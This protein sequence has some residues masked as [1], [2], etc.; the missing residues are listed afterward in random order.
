MGFSFPQFFS[1]F[2]SPSPTLSINALFDVLTDSV[3][4][5]WSQMARSF[6]TVMNIKSRLQCLYESGSHGN[7]Q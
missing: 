3:S 2:P 1:G 4:V 6:S 5:K 7:L